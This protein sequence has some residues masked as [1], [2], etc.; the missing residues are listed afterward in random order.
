[1]TEGRDAEGRDFKD[2]QRDQLA[3]T[4]LED[5]PNSLWR[6]LEL[7][8]AAGRTF[9]AIGY[10]GR[11]AYCEGCADRLAEKSTARPR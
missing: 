6:A 2:A 7:Y 9:R 10:T 5:Y 11:A 4:V 8:D 1:M 3:A